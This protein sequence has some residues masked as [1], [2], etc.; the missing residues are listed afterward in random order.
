MRVLQG[1]GDN[2]PFQPAKP[3]SHE[4][5]DYVREFYSL[6]G[7]SVHIAAMFLRVSRAE[8][9]P[10]MGNTRG[11]ASKDAYLVAYSGLE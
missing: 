10:Y 4:D 2:A 8:R 9:C 7:H 3:T 1:K 11:S 6:E 5:N